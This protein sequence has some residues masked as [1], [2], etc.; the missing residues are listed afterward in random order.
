MARVI[1]VIAQALT[2]PSNLKTMTQAQLLQLVAGYLQFTLSAD[3]D[4]FLKGVSDPISDEGIFYNTA[5]KRFKEW[6]ETYGKYQPIT[7]LRIG[8]TIDSY[9]TGD[10]LEQGFVNLDGRLISVIT[11]ITAQQKAYLETLFG[12]GGTLPNRRGLTTFTGV[13]AVGS[14]GGISVLEIAPDAGIIGSQ[15]VT[16]DLATKTEELR[17][18]TSDLKDNVISLRDKTEELLAAVRAGT[19]P[20]TTSFVKVWVGY[21]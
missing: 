16:T 2:P 4:F 9:T 5:Q 6:S 12:V 3:V 20:T 8:Q 11:G 10:E 21:P 7:D 14:I 13:P 15:T 19:S 1:P 17:G 18:S